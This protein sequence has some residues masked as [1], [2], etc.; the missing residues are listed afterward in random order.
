MWGSPGRFVGLVVVGLDVAGCDVVGCDVGCVGRG[1]C[2]AVGDE[3]GDVEA[4]VDG[5]AEG[6]G[7]DDAVGDVDVLGDG[8]GSGSSGTP[9]SENVSERPAA[10]E[11]SMVTSVSSPCCSNVT[12]PAS[13]PSTVLVS[14]P[15]TLRWTT[16]CCWVGSLTA[17]SMRL[18][19]LRAS[20]QIPASVVKSPAV[21]GFQKAAA[22][23][24]PDRLTA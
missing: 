18:A 14:I 23:T 19:P 11:V 20:R 24:P 7:E 10:P 15:A 4:L 5:D 8:D 16:S 1:D 22:V 21:P 9:I 12:R 17:M 6:V 3:V 2:E 13:A